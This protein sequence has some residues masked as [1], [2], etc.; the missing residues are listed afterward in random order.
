VPYSEILPPPDLA[1]LVECFWRIDDAAAEHR[2][3]PDGCIDIILMN[4]EARVVGTM[5]RAIMA[6]PS[7]APIVGVRFRPGEAAR[8]VPLA[9][10]ELTDLDAPLAAAW[11]DDGKALDDASPTTD[12]LLSALRARLAR[13]AEAADLPMRAAAAILERGGTVREAAER[14]SMSER[15]LA[16]RFTSRV[17]IAPKT[18]ARV[19][20]LRRAV[21]AIHGGANASQAAV[22]ARY[23]D[24]SHFTREAKEL[25]GVTPGAL[26]ASLRS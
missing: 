21:S 16:R 17:G 23:V 6:G 3:L 8:V 25:A 19:M 11:G 20:R 4:G 7:S 15:N 12:A 1:S 26:F 10:N 14:A 2:V 13:R 18:F 24:Q 5:T 22:I 9:P